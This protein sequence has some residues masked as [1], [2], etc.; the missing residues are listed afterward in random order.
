MGSDRYEIGEH[1]CVYVEDTKGCVLHDRM[2]NG[3]GFV[4]VGRCQLWRMFSVIETG[5][6][7]AILEVKIEM[8]NSG[9]EC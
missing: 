3:I 6:F 2:A 1:L 4:A 9:E 7:D 8:A 5:E